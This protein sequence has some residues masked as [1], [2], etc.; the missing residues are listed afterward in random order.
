[1]TLDT[2]AQQVRQAR[3]RFAAMAGSYFMG[4][5]NDNF[6]KQAVMLLAVTLGMKQFQGLVGAAFT[7]PFII[8]AA[9]AGWF[10]DRFPKRRIVI[11]AKSLELLAAFVGAYG[12]LTGHMW[13]MIGMVG[14]MGIQSTFFSPA[15][16][17]SIPELYPPSHVTQ[18]NAMLRMIVSVGIL[19]GITLAGFVLG[20]Q[21]NPLLGATFGHGMVGLAVIVFAIIGL[22]V[23]LGIP[24]R[25]AADPERPFPWSGPLDTCRELGAIWRDH[26]LGR[27]LLADVFI[28][29]AGVFQL[30]VINT[31]GKEQFH[32]GD[33]R[34]SLLV[35]SQL[36]GLA[37]GGL[38]SA[39]FAK[40]ERWFRVLLPAGLLMGL[41]MLALALVPSMPR[42]VQIPALYALIALAGAGGGLFM[43]PCESFLQV[44]PAPE[45]KG[46]VWA[47]ANFAAFLGMSAVSLAYTL[48]PALSALRPTLAYG[49]LGVASLAF[50]LWLRMEFRGKAWA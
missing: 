9:P 21:G 50:T 16:N 44:R 30:L 20:M 11:G 33:A 7:I 42:G 13:I 35:A 45:R 5:F 19:V 26:Q 18:A 40:G 24:S 48:I 37:C 27:V 39:R 31:L 10:A 22:G 1:M 2:E 3:S 6:Y 8:F 23:S 28:W 4:T 41:A 32:L 47:S 46:A 17:G 38:L 25:P 34:T 43:I 29:S 14:L 36:L 49:G 12:I 15:L